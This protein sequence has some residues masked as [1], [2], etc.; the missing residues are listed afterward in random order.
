MKN[1]LNDTTKELIARYLS[2]ECSA[3]EEKTLHDWRTQAPENEAAFLAFQKTS[4]LTNKHLASMGSK[5]ADID[6]EAEWDQFLKNIS[7][8]AE[9]PVRHIST[10]SSF[11]LWM[12]IAAS[13]V[14]LAIT[15]GLIYNLLYKGQDT[16]LTTSDF[17]FKT[18]LPDGSVVV[19]NRNSELRYAA[20]F[21][22]DNRTIELKGE[23]YF[24]VKPDATKPFIIN[25]GK[26]QVE[27]LGTSF[28]VTAYDSAANIKVVVE[29]GKVKLSLPALKKEVQLT[30]GQKGTVTP[31]ERSV[32]RQ[33]NEDV[34]YQSWNTMKIVFLDESL[35]NVV[36]T[37]N[38]T[39]HANIVLSAV[40]SDSCALTVTFDQQS[41]DSVLKVLESTLNLTIVRNGN[42]IEITAAGC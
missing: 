7:E 37:L 17:T 26:A 35:S 39:Y 21:G 36:E 33:Q 30:P 23:A 5:R 19:L 16:F 41:L 8:K 11:T 9:A 32:E 22:D 2:G 20:D 40:T 28:T 25:A 6:V 34:N 4:E 14:V 31:G 24:D 38:R 27:V 13:F 1:E 29:T 3:L 10:G 18:E 12:R 15:G 42:Q